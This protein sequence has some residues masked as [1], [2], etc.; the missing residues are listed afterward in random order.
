[1][2]KE[3][4]KNIFKIVGVGFALIVFL[5]AVMSL[6]GTFGAVFF[7]WHETFLFFVRQFLC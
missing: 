3:I 5:I 7:I 4:R 6:A 1:M 2:N